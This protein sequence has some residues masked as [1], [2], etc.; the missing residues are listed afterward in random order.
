MS[1]CRSAARA[2]PRRG[3]SPGRAP[4]WPAERSCPRRRGRRPVTRAKRSS[5][6][7]GHRS[8]RLRS[9]AIRLP[10][11]APSAMSAGTTSGSSASS[12]CRNRGRK[13]WSWRNWVTPRFYLL[14]GHRARRVGAL[15]PIED[16]D[17]VAVASQQH[18]AAQPGDPPTD[19]DDVGHGASSQCWSP[20]RPGHCRRTGRS[21][22][23]EGCRAD[24]VGAAEGLDPEL[25]GWLGIDDGHPVAARRR[26]SR[27]H[28]RPR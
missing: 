17:A 14:S 1:E 16:A 23:H 5:P 26:T 22:P 24:R 13:L 3:G 8:S 21:H 20:P 18:P 25:V 2:R 9:D 10:W 12:R 28:C 11:S 27:R 15:V 4:G 19:D 6:G 7:A